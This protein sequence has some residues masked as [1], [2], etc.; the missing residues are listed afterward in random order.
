M[1]SV[2]FLNLG[3][4]W[5]SPDSNL[6]IFNLI[7]AYPEAMTALPLVRNFTDAYGIEITFYEW[8]VAEPKGIVQLAHGL[9]EHARRYDHVAAALNRSGYTVYAD[10]HRGHGLTGA[11]QRARGEI[12]QQGNLGK[13]GMSAT[14]A[15]VHQ[16]TELIRSEN[17]SSPIFLIGHS[18]GSM[19]AQRIIKTNAQDYAGV[20]L[21]GSTLMLPGV[22]PSAGF[23]KK[24]DKLPDSTGKEWLSR[25]REVGIKFN[26]D[27]LI[28]PETAI[29]VF[30]LLGV[31]KLLGVPSKKLPSHLPVMLI[32]GSDDPLGG[33]RGNTML[34]NAFRK[35]GVQD[36]TLIIYPDARHEVFNELNKEEVLADVVDWL[37]AS[38]KP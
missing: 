10:D 19:L 16:L 20:V 4:F 29:D 1:G 27:P 25:D 14:I 32:A 24:W 28:F 23:N 18:W 21:S 7:R 22:V 26:A 2:C 12:K 9:G 8:P 13:G 3:V 37:N 34:M 17:P 5:E 15:Q 35:A 38:L 33:E 30:G 6:E 11:N 36:V 31:T